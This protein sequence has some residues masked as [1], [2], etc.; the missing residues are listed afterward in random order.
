MKHAVRQVLAVLVIAWLVAMA[1]ISAS[2]N[3]APAYIGNLRS[4]V[5]HKQSCRYLPAARNRTYF[6][7][8]AAAVDAGY[9]PCRKC[10]P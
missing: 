2:S 9:R 4:R 7:T 5:F 10:R 3:S 6:V 8:R 1:G